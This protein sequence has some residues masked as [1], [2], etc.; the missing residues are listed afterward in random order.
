MLNI[1]EQLA[2]VTTRIETEDGNGNLYSGTGF[3]FNLKMPNGTR[4]KL[5]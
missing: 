3:F 5:S 1:E 2:Y 4:N